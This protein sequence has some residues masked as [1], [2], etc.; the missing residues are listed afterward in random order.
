MFFDLNELNGHVDSGNQVHAR[1]IS[2]TIPND[3]RLIL[4]TC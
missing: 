4:L 1:G 3:S 2:Y